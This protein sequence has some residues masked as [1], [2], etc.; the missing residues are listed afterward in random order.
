M[1]I[2]K[3]YSD[4]FLAYVC[5]YRQYIE[6]IPLSLGTYNVDNQNINIFHTDQVFDTLK[7]S[8]LIPDKQI[9]ELKIIINELRHVRLDHT[10]TITIFNQ[11]LTD[12]RIWVKFVRNDPNIDINNL[13]DMY[14]NYNPDIDIFNVSRDKYNKKDSS[15]NEYMKNAFKVGVVLTG[16]VICAI[17]LK[18]IRKKF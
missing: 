8:Y 10:Q 2:L 17:G 11:T 6:I 12:E 14:V 15:F 7:R 9:N 5:T 18:I 4:T 13:C 3:D 16:I 1:T